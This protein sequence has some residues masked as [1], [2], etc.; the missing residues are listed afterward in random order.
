MKSSKS[1]LVAITVLVLAGLGA[2]AAVFP[3][4]TAE[5]L[6]AQAQRIV[7]G[8]VLRSWAS[9]DAEHKYIWTHYDVSVSDVLRGPRTATV[10]ISEP[11]GELDGIGQQ[12]SGV[13]PY[14]AGESVV[15]FLYQTPAGYWRSVGGPQ[16][17][18]T[19]DHEGRVHSNLEA[20][21]YLDVP[22]GA[23][24]AALATMEGLP[25]REFKRRVMNLAAAHPFKGRRRP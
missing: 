15:L 21:A 4:M 13:V 12:V 19:V 20:A 24:G 6:T 11:G 2:R 16:G 8:D 3:R 23:P 10:T 5:E 22:G 14:T 18:F 7:R 9:W 17:K 25:I 1:L